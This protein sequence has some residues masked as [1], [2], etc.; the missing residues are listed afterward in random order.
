MSLPCDTESVAVFGCLERTPPRPVHLP[1]PEDSCRWAGEKHAVPPPVVFDEKPHPSHLCIGHAI[2]LFIDPL[3]LVATI[4]RRRR[5]IPS[6]LQ[7][8][9]LLQ[10]VRVQ[11]QHRIGPRGRWDGREYLV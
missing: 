4:H 1:Q 10:R 2:R 7:M 11:G 6:P 9:H 8:R 3:P 5:E